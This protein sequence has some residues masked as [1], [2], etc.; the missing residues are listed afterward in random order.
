MVSYPKE[1][2]QE[3]KIKHRR[4]KSQKRTPELVKNI[5]DAIV[6]DHLSLRK[7]CKANGI[8]DGTFLRWVADDRDLA[9][10]YI[11]NI[12]IRT[13]TMA[14]EMLDIADDVTEDE[15]FDENGNR[16]ANNEWINRSRLRIDTRKF[17]IKVLEPKKYGDKLAIDSNASVTHS[18][19]T[20]NVN[21]STDPVQA[22]RDYQDFIKGK[23]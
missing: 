6:I 23:K 14:M 1:K 3:P 18:G 7:A 12:K 8:S 2:H 4:P 16:K 13:D 5:L 17:L 22:S 20:I 9:E 19:G 10:Q 21:I 15:V 11:N